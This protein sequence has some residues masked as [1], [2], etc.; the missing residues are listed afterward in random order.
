MD[1]V[2]I[3]IEYEIKIK[4]ITEIIK[5]ILF[6]HIDSNII[7]NITNC[8]IKKHIIKKTI[9]NNY[10]MIQYMSE[11]SLLSDY[12]RDKILYFLNI[13]IMEYCFVQLFYKENFTYFQKKE[14]NLQEKLFVILTILQ[15]TL[16]IDNK[17]YNKNIFNLFLLYVIIKFNYINK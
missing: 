11:V 15:I 9:V 1:D 4:K 17:N 14:L 12:D 10:G 7:E 13:T 3:M 8:E 5:E 16:D 6:P 2:N